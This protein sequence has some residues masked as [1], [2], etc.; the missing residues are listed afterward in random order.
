MSQPTTPLGRPPGR[1]H[2]EILEKKCFGS[3]G[4]SVIYQIKPKYV[5]TQELN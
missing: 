4:C 1:T 5:G 2:Q 3:A